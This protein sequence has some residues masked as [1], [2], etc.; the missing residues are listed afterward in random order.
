MR[1]LLRSVGLL[2][3]LLAPLLALAA[4]PPPRTAVFEVKGMTCA[5]CGK[6]IERALRELEGIER[7]AIDAKAERVIVVADP[8]ITP[9]V[10]QAT[11]AAAGF[12][13]AP[14]PSSP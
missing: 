8:K 9:E 12:E 2:I 6:A 14:L 10:I 7:V 4:D 13:A 3:L 11:I 1:S 5:L